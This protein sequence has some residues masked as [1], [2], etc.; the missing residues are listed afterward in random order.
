MENLIKPL[1]EKISV[2]D[3]SLAHVQTAVS[4]ADVLPILVIQRNSRIDRIAVQALMEK[5]LQIQASRIHFLDTPI[6][7]DRE[8]DKISS[9]AQNNDIF[10]VSL[11]QSG[12][13]GSP[14]QVFLPL[15]RLGKQLNKTATLI[16][17]HPVWNKYPRPLR[18]SGRLF[19]GKR[20]LSGAGRFRKILFS[21]GQ[22]TLE[23]GTPTP[24]HTLVTRRIDDREQEHLIRTHLF[25]TLVRLERAV[26]GPPMKSRQLTAQRVMRDRRLQEQIEH[27]SGGSEDKREKYRAQALKILHELA[28]DFRSRTVMRFRKVLDWAWPRVIEGFWV[29]EEG[30]E[31]YR[32]KA[33]QAP[34]LLMPCHRSHAD[35]LLLSYLFHR[36]SLMIPYIAAG[37][38][39][40]FWPMGPIF[41]H[42]GAYF[43]RRSFKGDRLYPVVLEAYIRRLLKDHI[44]QEFFPE[45]TRSRTGKLLHPKTGLLSINVN[46]VRRAEIHDLLMAPVSITYGRLFESTSYLREADGETKEK[47]SAKSVLRTTRLLGKNFGKV[48]LS[49]GDPFFLSEYLATRNINLQQLTDPEFREFTTEL[50]YDVVRSIQKATRVTPVAI[51]SL[52]FLSNIR[53]GLSKSGLLRRLEYALAFFKDRNAPMAELDTDPETQVF[54]VLHHLVQAG[55][56]QEL[57]VDGETVYRPVDDHRNYLEYYKNNIVHL[58]VHVSFVSIAIL[59]AKRNRIPRSVLCEHYRFLHKLFAMEFVYDTHEPDETQVDRELNILKAHRLVQMDKDDVIV[60]PEALFVLRN[61]SVILVSYLESYFTVLDSYYTIARSDDETP[62]NIIPSVLSRGRYLY[63]MGEINRR[64]SISKFYYQTGHQWMNRS[65]IVNWPALSVDLRKETDTEATRTYRELKKNIRAYIS[66]IYG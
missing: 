21:P 57:H 52:M 45:G 28:A 36:Y 47:E 39:L 40:S 9:W 16:P 46:M 2:S 3:F 48:Y 6:D 25:R 27:L 20:T 33:R 1:F 60:P 13:S 56:I 10:L 23:V 63:T 42:S 44:P 53:K 43:I 66:A 15:Q 38:N 41:R 50:G 19:G 17:V 32:E 51:L 34:A 30:I 58:F 64:E 18:S 5:H 8:T 37:I 61:I 29:D 59:R 7:W 22:I 54:K 24:I 26:I 49:F 55:S 11:A 31:R 65:G 12:K 62:P 35:Y 4:E 14:C